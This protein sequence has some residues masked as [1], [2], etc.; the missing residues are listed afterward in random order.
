MDRPNVQVTVCILL[1]V[2][3]VDFHIVFSAFCIECFVNDYQEHLI[4]DMDNNG[5]SYVKVLSVFS[6]WFV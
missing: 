1:V 6:Y 5:S 4:L 3:L 2:C